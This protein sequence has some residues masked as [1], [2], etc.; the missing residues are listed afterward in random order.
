VSSIQVINDAL[1]GR[2]KLQV[3]LMLRVRLLSRQPEQ[4]INV[5]AHLIAGAS[6]AFERCG[7][8]RLQLF[9]RLDNVK[10]AGH[11]RDGG[12]QFVTGQTQQRMLSAYVGLQLIQK[13]IKGRSD[14][15]QFRF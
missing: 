12:A 7:I 6:Q 1:Q 11:Y 10:C 3:F 2:A 5:V 14:G 15:L 9:A 8:V 13:T 4:H